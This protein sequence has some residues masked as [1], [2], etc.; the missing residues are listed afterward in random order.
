MDNN[1]EEELL[2]LK[3]ENSLL[4]KENLRL[5]KLL[6]DNNISYEIEEPNKLDVL[7]KIDIFLS[8]FKGNPNCL[9][10]Y[11]ETT[12]GKKGYS[13]VCKNKFKFVCQIKTT[14]CKECKNKEYLKYDKYSLAEH[15]KG[16]KDY[17]IYPMLEDNTCYFLVLDFDGKDYTL[18]TVKDAVKGFIEVCKKHN[19]TPVLESSRSGL[20]FHIWIFFEENIKAKSARLLGDYLLKEAIS[21]NPNVNY[22][23]FDRFFPSQDYLTKDGL[24]NLIALPLNKN[25]FVNGKRAFLDDNFNPYLDQLNYLKTIKKI[26][27][28]ELELLLKNLKKEDIPLEFNL[29]KINKLKLNLYDFPMNLNILLKNSIFIHKENLSFK[30]LNLLKSLATLSNPEFYDKQA[31]RLSTYNIS[32]IVELYEETDNYIALPRGIL[33][34]LKQVL[35]YFGVNYKIIDE[36]TKLNNVSLSLNLSL[37]SYQEQAVNALIEKD[38]GI[39]I[40]ETGSGKT[41]MSLALACMLQKPCAIIVDGNNLLKQWQEKIKEYVKLNDSEFSPGT[42]NATKKKLTGIIDVISIASLK[43]ASTDLFNKY[44]IVIFDECHHLASPNNIKVV[45]QFNA[46]RIYGLTATISRYDKLEKIIYKIIGPII[47]KVI[48][49]NKKDFVK[50][51]KPIYTKIKDKPEYTIKQY[52]EILDDLSLDYER[53]KLI[54]DNVIIEYEK[55]KNI[56]ILTK[57]INQINTLTS[58]LKDKCPNILA[59]SGQATKEEKQEFDNK[60]KNL[61]NKFII[62][63]TGDYLGEGFDLNILDVLFIA[64]PIKWEGLLVQYVGRIE[65]TNTNKKQVTVYDFVDLK[66]RMFVNMFSIRLKKYKELNY[67]IEENT[68]EEILYEIDNYKD[69]LLEDLGLADEVIFIINYG[70]NNIIKE[71]AANVTNLTIIT[72]IDLENIN[73]RVI[74]K[75][76]KTNVIIIDHKLIW[77]GEI[78]P[79]SYNYKDSFSIIRLE[80]REYADTIIKEVDVFR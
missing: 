21:E 36:R 15:F 1:L 74:K 67:Q 30:A 23:T 20:G 14:G 60:I 68:K 46:S 72:N 76:V 56:L 37:Y 73:V 43:G 49:T 11:Y 27:K 24:G 12:T 51:L 19:I 52:N 47:Y 50:V 9:A 61:T 18:D 13:I 54:C 40:A 5:K 6:D 44:E 79:F 4:L 7:T 58:I 10:E 77:Y 57:R 71:L 62:I 2:K 59:I 22:K 53:N 34:D 31:K 65:R 26:T 42:Y 39:L 16:S 64:L 29:K 17:G 41:I 69:I 66:I 75:E 25:Y 48:D 32:R 38:N 55:G 35:T 45:N 70:I 33:D 78:N 80:D 8:Y 28:I 3:T 63:S